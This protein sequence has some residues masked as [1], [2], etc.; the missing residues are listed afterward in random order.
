MLCWLSDT[1]SYQNV[2][3]CVK[4]VKPVGAILFLRKN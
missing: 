2:V 3:S 1:V 4:N